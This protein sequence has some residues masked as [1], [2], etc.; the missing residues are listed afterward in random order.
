MAECQHEDFVAHVA[1]NR[2]TADGSSEPHSFAAD[3]R[4]KCA[5]CGVAFGFRCRDIGLLPDRPAVSPT[6]L[7]IRL[8]LISPAELE[9]LGP[10]A[11]MRTPGS[12]PGFGVRF[13]DG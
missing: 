11:A 9:L 3:V 1:V 13:R 8:P 4:V 10:L 12:Y 5:Q 6:A 7:E 2:L